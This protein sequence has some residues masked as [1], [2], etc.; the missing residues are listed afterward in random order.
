MTE[1][2]SFL[3]RM[4][5]V[6]YDSLL[7]ISVLLF[8]T[9]PA[10]LLNHGEAIAPE[11]QVY[12]IWLWL[13]ASLYFVIPWKR[14]GQTLGMQSWK[15]RLVQESGKPVTWVQAWMR[16]LL[17]LVSWLPLGLGFIWSL[18]DKKRQTWHDRWTGT[19]LIVEEKKT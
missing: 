19:K 12:K 14:K 16:V 13:V 5:A 18:F 6:F 10:L 7:L 9:I 1:R 17:A 4:G 2:C 8:A 11:N 3:R 15:I